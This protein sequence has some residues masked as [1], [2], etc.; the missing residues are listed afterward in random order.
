MQVLFGL[1]AKRLIH[2]VPSGIVHARCFGVCCHDIIDKKVAII[3]LLVLRV[4]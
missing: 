4:L 3:E 2:L 1:R